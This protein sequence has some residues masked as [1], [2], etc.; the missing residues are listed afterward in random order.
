MDKFID[1]NNY[2]ADYQSFILNCII[3]KLSKVLGFDT[4][5]L[6]SNNGKHLFL[7]VRSDE[8]DL[9]RLAQQQ[10]FRLKLE[11]G[12]SDMIS[13]EPCDELL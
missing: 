6:L 12:H 8:K 9:K 3:Y 4:V 10:D 2:K 13:L 11:I 5:L 1:T 7:L